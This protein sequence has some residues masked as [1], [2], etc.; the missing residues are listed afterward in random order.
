MDKAA[1]PNFHKLD[2]TDSMRDV[3]ISVVY[4][5]LKQ[6]A[7]ALGRFDSYTSHQFSYN[8]IS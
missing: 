7:K 3:D 1:K 8:V 6:R 4:L 2:S 5:P